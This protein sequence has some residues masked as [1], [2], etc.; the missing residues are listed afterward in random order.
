M[1][2]ILPD[3]PDGTANLANTSRLLL[4]S[5]QVIAADID[6]HAREYRLAHR[7]TDLGTSATAIREGLPHVKYQ[8]RE[9]GAVAN[10]HSAVDS[11]DVIRHGKAL[12]LAEARFNR[13][14]RS[15]W[16]N[17]VQP[18]DEPTF[19]RLLAVYRGLLLKFVFDSNRSHSVVTNASQE[20][21]RQ[22]CTGEV[23][24]TW[25][26]AAGFVK[27][28]AKLSRQIGEAIAHLFDFHGDAF[29]DLCDNLPLAGQAVVGRCLASHPRSKQPLREGFLEETELT[30][31]VKALGPRWERLILGG[32]N[33]VTSNLESACKK[34][35][36]HELLANRKGG[37]VWSEEELAELSAANRD[38]M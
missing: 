17:H 33:Y 9:V 26:K 32:E 21:F 36:L 19:H 29:S 15:F 4:L 27:F 12:L 5:L 10:V 1:R 18:S 16:V 13:A 6:W 2:A 25:E 20:L 3:M 23:S 35:W 14:W 22:V 30:E 8:T 28:Y 11:G 31:A 24:W 7:R 34:Y 37:H 38:E